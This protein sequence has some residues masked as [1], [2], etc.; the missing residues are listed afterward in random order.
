MNETGAPKKGHEKEKYHVR[1]SAFVSLIKRS[2]S[3]VILGLFHN[4]FSKHRGF[5]QNAHVPEDR[6]SA[7][8]HGVP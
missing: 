2:L 6:Q 1:L 8:Q 5:Q 3:Q 7:G 4:I